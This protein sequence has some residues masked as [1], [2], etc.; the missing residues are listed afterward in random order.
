MRVPEGS[1]TTLVEIVGLV[2]MVASAG[3]WEP[4][5]GLFCAGVVLVLLGWVVGARSRL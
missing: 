2:L 1:V 4:L 5:A 3:L